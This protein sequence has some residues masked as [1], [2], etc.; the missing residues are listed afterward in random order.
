MPTTPA[1]IYVFNE[2]DRDLLLELGLTMLSGGGTSAY[3]FV[4][5][6]DKADAIGDITYALSDTITF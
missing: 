5:D 3:A 6:R 2:K 1:F 4:Y